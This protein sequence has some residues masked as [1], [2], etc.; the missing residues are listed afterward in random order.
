MNKIHTIKMFKTSKFY[1]LFLLGAILSSCNGEAKK[2]PKP[3]IT[4]GLTFNSSYKELDKAFSWAKNKALSYA[5]DN[6][7]PVGYWYEAALPDRE[8]FCM[9]DVSHQALGAELLGLG[10]HNYN[11]FLKFAQNISKEKDYCTY[12]EINR[13]NKPAPVDY[14]NDQDFWYNLPANFDITYSAYR[15]YKWTGNEEYLNNPDLI[16]FY[17]LTLNDYLDRWELGSDK[18]LNRSRSLNSPENPEKSRFGNKRGIPTY[19]EGG[20][21]ETS[22]GI[23]MTASIVAAYKAYSEMLKLRND[24]PKSLKYGQKAQQEQAFLNEFWWDTEKQEYRSI[25][26]GD[27]SYDYFMVGENQAFL[28]YLFYFNAIQDASKIS[29]LLDKY[30]ANYG[31]LIV[32]LKSYLPI[33]FY[34]NNKST[35]ANSM[36]INLCSPLNPR[37]AYP[38]NSFTVIEAIT[39]GL[40]GIDADAPLNGFMSLSRLDKENEWAEITNVP[41]LSNIVGVKHFGKTKSIAHNILGATIKWTAKI[42][43]VHEFL[44]VNGKKTN[45]TVDSNSPQ[46]Y[47]YITIDLKED[48]K[49]TVSTTS[50]AI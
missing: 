8:A 11:M 45:C 31:K 41:L 13:Y 50:K 24:L 42:Q 9:R 35:L 16:N 10:K 2:Q 5:H 1:L 47:S 26:Y 48:E 34:E 7:E 39:I 3:I 37:R 33:I 36:I 20:R 22:L 29:D 44:F 17:E 21:G 38:E 14:E 27:G 19:N 30:E 15:L 6:S 18:T 28:H 46:P 12:W 49:V 40:M 23:D 32:E 25:L 4:G 43:G